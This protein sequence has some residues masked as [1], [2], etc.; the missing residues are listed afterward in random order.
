MFYFV[1]EDTE[2][3]WKLLE[4]IISVSSTNSFKPSTYT[5]PYCHHVE[6]DKDVLIKGQA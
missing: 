4:K 2:T 3:F 6:G 1:E 5:S